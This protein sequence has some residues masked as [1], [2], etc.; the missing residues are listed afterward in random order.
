VFGGGIIPDEDAQALE[1]SGVQKVFRPGTG[2]SEIVSWVQA[3]VA[4]RV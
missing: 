3:H 1:A 4:A 2:L